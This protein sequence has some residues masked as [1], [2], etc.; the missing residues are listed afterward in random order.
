MRCASLPDEWWAKKAAEWSPGLST[1]YK[2][3]RA[4][5]RPK[6]IWEDEINNFLRAEG[7][8]DET[9][10]VKR[11]NNDWIKSA[12]YQKVWKKMGNK[13]AMTAAAAPDTGHQ[14]RRRTVDS[15]WH[16]PRIRLCRD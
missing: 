12:E 5:V 3:Y 7:T 13:F 15:V 1:K 4:V 11:K 6:K 9:S 8:E 10:K 14:R 2:T 16:L